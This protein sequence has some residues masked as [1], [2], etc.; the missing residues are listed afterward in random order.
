MKKII[1]IILFIIVMLQ[2][3]DIVAQPAKEKL[4]FHSIEQLGLINGKGAT[5]ALFQTVNGLEYRGFFAGVGTGI[6]YYRYRSVPLFMDIRKEFGQKKRKWFVYADAGHHFPWVDQ[7]ES[8][9]LIW[10]PK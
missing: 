10:G 7:N 2:A 5:A 9:N 6:D 3:M 1:R 8:Q 4:R